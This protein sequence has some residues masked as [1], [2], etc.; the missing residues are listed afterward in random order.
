MVILNK[1]IAYMLMIFVSVGSLYSMNTS[2]GGYPLNRALCGVINQVPASQVNDL[3]ELMI[4]YD[5]LSQELPTKIVASATRAVGL[6]TYTCNQVLYYQQVCTRLETE[7]DGLAQEQAAENFRNEEREY[8]EKKRAIDASVQRL[9]Q[10]PTVLERINQARLEAVD[11]YITT[12][13]NAVVRVT[14]SIAQSTPVQGVVHVGNFLVNPYVTT[15][16][17]MLGGALLAGEQLSGEYDPLTHA[18]AVYLVGQFVVVAI[19]NW[20]LNSKPSTMLCNTGLLLYACSDGNVGTLGQFLI[21]GSACVCV[22]EKMVGFVSPKKGD[23]KKNSGNK[24]ETKKTT[25]KKCC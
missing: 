15:A 6:T 5:A 14:D 13:Y 21:V 16:E 17:C 2:R 3:D 19:Y 25:T 9:L 1:F 18:C 4:R 11:S 12:P 20:L 22:A 23:D 10:N 24:V 7:K 8:A